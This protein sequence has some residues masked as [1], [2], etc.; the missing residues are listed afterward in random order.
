M[1][2]VFLAGPYCADT[3]RGTVENIRYAESVAVKLWQMGAAVIC[4][5]LNSALLSGICAE[6][7]FL[8]GYLEILERCDGLVAFSAWERSQG[9]MAE[10]EHAVLKDIPRFDWTWEERFIGN[11]LREDLRPEKLAELIQYSRESHNA[12]TAPSARLVLLNGSKNTR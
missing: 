6:E 9:A 4:P 2:V 10:V 5:H 1:K 7:C 3:H 12:L 11:W 8:Q